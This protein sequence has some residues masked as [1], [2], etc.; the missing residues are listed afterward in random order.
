MRRWSVPAFLLCIAG[1]VLCT[2]LE[3]QQRRPGRSV[4]LPPGARLAVVASNSRGG[5]QVDTVVAD[6]LVS[7]L[8]GA[9]WRV[10]ERLELDAVLREQQLA[11]SGV[12]DPNTAVLAGK[13]AGAQYLIIAR[14]TEFGIRDN[15]V[16]GLFGLGPFGGLQVRTAT[17]R[18]VLDARV[19]DVRT[20][21]VLGSASGEG[22]I[23]NYGG[24]VVG[25]SWV[26]GSISLGGVDVNSRE[27]SESL[28]GRTARRAIDELMRRLFGS[29]SEQPGRVLA[30]AAD[31]VCII[32]LGTEDGLQVGDTLELVRLEQIRDREGDPVWSEEVR[33]GTLRVTEVRADRAKA[34]LVEGASP[35]EGLLVRALK[36]ERARDRTR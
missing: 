29:T 31:G 11:S 26:G 16:G 17:G 1:T 7:A 35:E 15:R 20:G 23:V 27:W 4:D 24:T 28:L 3:G 19:V 32:N 9:G 21:D 25:G 22:K 14:A 2:P 36:R 30:V 10:L 34:T 8:R 5:S 18:V 33:V 12:V 13:L 6:M